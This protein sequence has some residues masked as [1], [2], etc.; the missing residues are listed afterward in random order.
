MKV[1]RPSL[2][3]PRV[4]RQPPDL[5]FHA[6]DPLL[7]VFISRPPLPLFS[8]FGLP[9]AA[10]VAGVDSNLMGEGIKFQDSLHRA[11]EKRAVVGHD[12]DGAVVAGQKTF[13]PLQRLDVQVIG[14]LVEEEKLRAD[15]QQ[16]G[17]AEAGLLPAAED[18]HRRALI[19]GVEAQS[20]Q[21][22]L[23]VVGHGIATGGLEASQRVGVLVHQARQF[24]ALGD[25]HLPGQ[26]L[27]LALCLAQ[28]LYRLAHH[29]AD[30][31][32]R[33]KL[34]RLGQV[35]GGH[36]GRRKAHAAPVWSPLADAAQPC[37]DRPGQC[38]VVLPQPLGPT[39][40]T[41]SPGSTTK[42]MFSR[43]TPSA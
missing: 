19:H 36:A 14:R 6:G 40:P 9:V 43:I 17:Q 25:G 39:R 27:H 34:Q 7:L 4:R 42:E 8:V 28:P 31:R 5:G 37:T 1:G 18:G 22:G 38:N 23:N 20:G 29:V 33:L 16:A 12:K 30:G 21:D 32:L 24:V 11:V 2:D 3:P 15:Q 10:I 13:Q 41:R 35:T 26:R